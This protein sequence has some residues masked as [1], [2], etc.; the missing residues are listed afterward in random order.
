MIL[1]VEDDLQDSFLLTDQ[2]VR[3]GLEDDVRLIRNGRDALDF[4]LQVSPLPYA[5]FLDLKLPGLSGIALLREIRNEP[6]LH[7]LPVIVTTNSV[8]AHDAEMCARLGVAA[9]QSKPVRMEIFK[10]IIESVE[11]ERPFLPRPID[12]HFVQLAS[13]MLPEEA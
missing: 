6:R 1:V 8:N 9:F 7:D 3:A 2:V 4:L 13:P 5:V 10:M 12:P 11:S